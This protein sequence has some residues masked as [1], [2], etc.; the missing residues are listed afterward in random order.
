MVCPTLYLQPGPRSTHGLVI[1]ICQPR[2]LSLFCV[3]RL[4]NFGRFVGWTEEF[5]RLMVF[6]NRNGKVIS[7]NLNPMYAT[8]PLPYRLEPGNDWPAQIKTNLS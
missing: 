1:T 2:F 7:V 6:K 8:G 3:G 4:F 5:V